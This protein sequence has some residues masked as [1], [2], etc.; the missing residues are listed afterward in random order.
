MKAGPVQTNA[1]RPQPP[2]RLKHA[3]PFNAE[4]F[5]RGERRTCSACPLWTATK[6]GKRGKAIAG[7]NFQEVSDQLNRL[8]GEL[9]QHLSGLGITAVADA[10]IANGAAVPVGSTEQFKPTWTARIDRLVP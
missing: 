1:D 7:T 10:A 6:P 5:S 9:V 2:R 4:I 8:E 3:F